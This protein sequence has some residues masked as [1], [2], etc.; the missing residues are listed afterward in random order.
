MVSEPLGTQRSWQSD[1]YS[2]RENTKFVSPMYKHTAMPLLCY[3][4]VYPSSLT[5]DQKQLHL[6]IITINYWWLRKVYS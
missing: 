4:T 3:G 1:S 5:D 6:E 2:V